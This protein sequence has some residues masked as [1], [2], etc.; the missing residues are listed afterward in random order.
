MCDEKTLMPLVEQINRLREEFHETKADRISE[1]EAKKEIAQIEA[2]V[3]LVKGVL[4]FAV[5]VAVVFCVGVPL[6]LLLCGCVLGGSNWQA[7]MSYCAIGAG[8]LIVVLAVVIAKMV[9]GL[10]FKNRPPTN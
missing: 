9:L 3:E 10:M 5:L 4:T 6:V 2:P 1:R 8:V 7:L